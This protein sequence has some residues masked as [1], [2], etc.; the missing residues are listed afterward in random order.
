M[1][2][3]NDLFDAWNSHDIE[4]AADFYSADYSGVD[5]SQAAPQT[6]KEGIR[7]MISTYLDAFPDFKIQREE[8]IS[9]TNRVVVVWRAQGTHQG[10]LLNIPPTG[11]KILA[12]GV[13]VITIENNLVKHA[14]YFWD[15]AGLLRDIGLLPELAPS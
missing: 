11:R 7:R 12:R 1:E 15:V 3:V 13:T 9:E 5:V 4:R 2:L 10:K 8:T 6:G 14:L